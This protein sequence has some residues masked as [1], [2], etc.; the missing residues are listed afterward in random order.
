MTA[1]DHWGFGVRWQRP[2]GDVVVI[3]A[4]GNG[5][6]MIELADEQSTE[7]LPRW[8]TWVT[9]VSADAWVLA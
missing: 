1:A 7:Y 6:L 2:E 9:A 4:R 8:S 5:K 3:V